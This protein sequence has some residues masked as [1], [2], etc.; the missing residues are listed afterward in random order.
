[1][2]EEISN[3][4]KEQATG[5]SQVAQAIAQMDRITQ[6]NAAMVEQSSTAASAL[7]EQAQRLSEAIAV[8]S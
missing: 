3:A 8:F 4:S 6:E 2:I 1:M 5:I 7:S